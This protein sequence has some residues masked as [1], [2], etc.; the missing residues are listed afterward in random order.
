VTSTLRAGV[1]GSSDELHG[2]KERRPTRSPLSFDKI[3]RLMVAYG[4]RRS[5]RHCLKILSITG[6]QNTFGDLETAIRRLQIIS[7]TN[8]SGTCSNS[9]PQI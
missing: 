2:V 6:R 3:Q 5:L 1:F 7:L 8:G 4:R 9:P